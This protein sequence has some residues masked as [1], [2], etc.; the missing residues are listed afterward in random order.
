MVVT[1]GFSILF[2]VVPFYDSMGPYFITSSSNVFRP[3]PFWCCC[4][5]DNVNNTCFS[6]LFLRETSNFSLSIASLVCILFN[7]GWFFS[8]QMNQYCQFKHQVSFLKLLSV[9]A[10]LH[11]FSIWDISNWFTVLKNNCYT[12]DKTFLFW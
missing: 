1:V 7:K 4:F 10:I 12:W 5:I 2:A 9:V 6:F 3:I 11:S 8:I